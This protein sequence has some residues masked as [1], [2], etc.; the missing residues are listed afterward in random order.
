MQQR[1][2]EGLPSL[3]LPI[4]RI[5]G[6]LKY[7]RPQSTASQSLL[8]CTASRTQYQGLLAYIQYLSIYRRYTRTHGT[9]H[10]TNTAA[11]FHQ[12]ETAYNMLRIVPV[13]YQE[14]RSRQIVDGSFEMLEA[15]LN[16]VRYRSYPDWDDNDTLMDLSRCSKQ[17]LTK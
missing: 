4:S 3:C 7:L 17:S 16:K 10:S 5:S 6:H 2:K 9:N 12:F 1:N 11:N 15:E 8:L 14:F 13:S